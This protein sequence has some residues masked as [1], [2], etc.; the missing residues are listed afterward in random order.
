MT[1]AVQRALDA[2]PPLSDEKRRTIVGL[3]CVTPDTNSPTSEIPKVGLSVVGGLLTVLTPS[4]PVGVSA[5]RFGSFRALSETGIL[6][7]VQPNGY[8][9]PELCRFR[10]PAAPQKKKQVR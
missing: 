3:L 4:T 9:L 6:P 10:F 1:R 7:F 2:A 8:L 5:G